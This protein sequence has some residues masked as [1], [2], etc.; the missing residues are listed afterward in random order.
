VSSESSDLIKALEHR[1]GYTFN[2]KGLLME[3]LTHKSHHYENMDS[4]G[5]YN[6]RLEFLGDSVLGLSIA[7]ELFNMP[8]VFDE[9]MMSKVK[10]YIVKG[11]V[12]SEVAI[13]LG[14]G[15][16]L[17]LGRGEEDSGGRAKRSLLANVIEAV[18]G[19]VYAEAGYE[20]ARQ[21]VLRL[22][23]HRLREAIESGLYKDY[24]S[25]LQEASQEIYS[26]LPEY[27]VVEEA[28]PEHEK[29]FHV[30]VHVN[31]SLLGTGNGPNKK[32][33]QQSAAKEALARIG[34]AGQGQS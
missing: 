6:E 26:R 32:E 8:D 23:G 20:E 9:S 16:Y 5:G 25:E 24:K 13:G 21:L 3:A 2:D 29:T 18:I 11:E 15:D 31:G 22:F 30:E 17:K 28:G 10:S 19:A 33:A 7:G 1:L 27:R 34:K 14:I 4:S 12:I